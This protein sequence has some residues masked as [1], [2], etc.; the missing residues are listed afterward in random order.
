M[1]HELRVSMHVPRPREQVFAF[2][3]DASN[4]ARITPPELGFEILSPEPL[5]MQSGTYIEY[6]LKVWGVPIYWRTLIRLWRPPHEFV[7]DQ[8]AGPYAEWSHHHVFEESADGGTHIHDR[9]RY[10]LPLEPFGDA[11]YPLVKRE[12]AR[13]FAFRQSVVARIYAHA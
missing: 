13:I 3:S 8:L 1:R 6:R 4:L 12:L 10:R 5:E 2:F 11:A 9:V 7:D